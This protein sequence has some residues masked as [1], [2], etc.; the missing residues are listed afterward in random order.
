MKTSPTVTAGSH[1][2]FGATAERYRL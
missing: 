1:S 2:L